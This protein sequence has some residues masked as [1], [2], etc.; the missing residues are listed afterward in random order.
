MERRQFLRIVTGAAVGSLPGL[1]LCLLPPFMTSQTILCLVRQRSI[2]RT[3]HFWPAPGEAVAVEY[4]VAIL[5]TPYHP[6]QNR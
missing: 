2:V 6:T 4:P 3:Y 5:V 1:P